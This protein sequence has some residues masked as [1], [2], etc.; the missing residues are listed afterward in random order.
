MLAHIIIRQEAVKLN[1]EVEVLLG[2]S[3]ISNTLYWGKLRETGEKYIITDLATA[4]HILG[5]AIGKVPHGYTY[6]IV[7]FSIPVIV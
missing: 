7:S 1:P 4:K 3:P 2:Q 6:E 5:I